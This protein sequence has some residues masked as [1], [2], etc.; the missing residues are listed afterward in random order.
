[1]SINWFTH[2]AYVKYKNECLLN[3]L[4]D[5]TANT[6]KDYKISETNT[7]GK[8]N[9]D[10]CLWTTYADYLRFKNT[11]LML[12]DISGDHVSLNGNSNTINM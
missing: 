5:G 6:C 7:N 1:M 10:N 9:G 8:K 3:K 4:S 12:R 2:T 11:K